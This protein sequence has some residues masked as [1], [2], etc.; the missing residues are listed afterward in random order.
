M[1]EAADRKGPVDNN[2]DGASSSG[3]RRS[4]FA[5]SKIDA[6]TP[7]GVGA[8]RLAANGKYALYLWGR[9]ISLCVYFCVR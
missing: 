1:R 7:K 8:V 5:S 6:A 9:S 3:G 4:V 2:S